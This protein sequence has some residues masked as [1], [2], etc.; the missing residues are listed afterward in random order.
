MTCEE[1]A[2]QLAA[3]LDGELT[4]AETALVERHV[5]TC[6]VCAR[7]IAGGRRL[8]ALLDEHFAAAPVDLDA[9]FAALWQ[10][11]GAESRPGRVVRGDFSRRSAFRRTV[12]RI[13]A[14]TLAAGL[15]FGLWWMGP[16]AQTPRD[17]GEGA[18]A[19]AARVVAP[20]KIAKAPASAQEPRIVAAKPKPA[21]EPPTAVAR[22]ERPARRDAKK[23]PI[24]QVAQVE[25]KLPRDVRRRAEMFLDYS[26]VKR[27]DE[28][29]NFDAVMATGKATE[30]SRS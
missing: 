5:A 1:T 6:V 30:D 11:T 29:E 19:P 18:L 4:A 8:N 24:E 28:L 23:D 17:G 15:A 22:A 25:E 27:L 20:E 3:Y 9:R 2:G 16:A 10:Q 13:A 14:G 12:T 26:I 7:E 21:A